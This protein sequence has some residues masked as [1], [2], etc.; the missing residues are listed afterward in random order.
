[1]RE[2]KFRVWDDEQKLIC[3]SDSIFWHNGDQYITWFS[4]TCEASIK[5]VSVYQYTGLKDKNGVEIYEGD[6]VEFTY[7]WFDGNVA[8]STLT[9]MIVYS[10]ALMSFQLKGVKNKEWEQHTGYEN[11]QEYLTPF[12]EFNFEDADFEVIGNIHEEQGE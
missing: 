4:G 1:M 12:S 5:D 6:K 11:D 10:D 7:W 2:I 9:G 3:A 8:E